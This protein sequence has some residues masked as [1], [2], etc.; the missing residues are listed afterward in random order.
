MRLPDILLNVFVVLIAIFLVAPIV[1]VLIS[2]V[3]A[4]NY[5][6]FP[7]SGF[8][9]KH[10]ADAI[11]DDHFVRA[12]QVSLITALSAASCALLLGVPAAIGLSRYEFP[13]RNTIQALLMSPLMIPTLVIGITLL[14]YYSALRVSASV[15]TIVGGHIVITLPFAVR[16]MMAA[17]AGVD[18]RLELAAMSMGAP[19]IKAFVQVT[20]PNIS[21]GLMGAFTFAA[22]IS[23]DD[24]GLALFI[25]PSRAQTLPVAIFTYLDQNYEPLIMAVSSFMILVSTVAVLVLDRAVGL[26][27]IMMNTQAR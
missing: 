6:H 12:F 3:N 11:S 16:L 20:L 26:S 5:I 7:P 24:V 18:R 1:L 4:S 21:A 27:R 13:G 8:S 15:L 9:L 2:S 22:I 23:F 25:A 17:L 10:Y 19:P 14:H